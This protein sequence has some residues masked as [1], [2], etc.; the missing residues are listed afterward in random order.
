LGIERLRR[1]VRDDGDGAA[2]RASLWP[3]LA[4]TVTATRRFAASFWIV[5]RAYPTFAGFAVLLPAIPAG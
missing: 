4:A 2:G 5:P 1:S 3:G